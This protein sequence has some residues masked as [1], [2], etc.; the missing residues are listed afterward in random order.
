VVLD[1]IFGL[2]DR[3]SIV[4][5]GARRGGAGRNWIH[6]VLL[7]STIR[8]EITMVIL[9]KLLA[10]DIWSKELILLCFLSAN[11][12]RVASCTADDGTRVALFSLN[13]KGPAW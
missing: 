4:E 10:G 11:G 1:I 12:R 2:Q 7:G 13:K 3:T 8:Y 6:K 9:F 5:T